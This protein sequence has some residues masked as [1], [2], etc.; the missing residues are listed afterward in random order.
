M[1]IV[2]DLEFNCSNNSYVSEKNG[3]RLTHEIIEIGAVK[4]DDNLK[5]IDRFCSFIK[6]SVYTKVNSEVSKLTDITTDMIYDGKDFKEAINEF[7]DWCGDAPFV[8]WS[9]NV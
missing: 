1:Y 7:L 6:P 8:T 3:I 5:E 2:M 9:E 4:L